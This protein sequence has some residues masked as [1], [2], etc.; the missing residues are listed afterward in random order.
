MSDYAQ[1]GGPAP[2]GGMMGRARTGNPVAV[3]GWIA[4]AAAMMTLL[5]VFNIIGGLAALVH[6]RYYVIGPNQVLAFNLVGWG[7]I[8]LIIGLLAVFAGL[9]LFTGAIWARIAA[10]VIASINAVAQ[11]AFV[12]ANPTWSLIVIGFDVLVIWTILVHGKEEAATMY[13]MSG[14]RERPGYR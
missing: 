4:F 13:G 7:W 2:G 10:V 12:A 6:P 9:A 5:G 11:L 14:G 3:G 1:R 8:H